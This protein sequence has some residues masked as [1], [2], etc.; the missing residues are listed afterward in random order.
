VRYIAKAK[1]D[2]AKTLMG[3]CRI[4]FTWKDHL[5]LQEYCKTKS[6]PKDGLEWILRQGDYK[7]KHKEI[8]LCMFAFLG[9]EVDLKELVKQG[10]NH[11]PPPQGW[12][13]PAISYCLARDNDRCF[14]TLLSHSTYPIISYGMIEASK[15]KSP[16]CFV[17]GLEYLPN[18]DSLLI[19]LWALW[20]NWTRPLLPKEVQK[21]ILKRAHPVVLN[22][23]LKVEENSNKNLGSQY[24]ESQKAI[25]QEIAYRKIKEQN[26]KDS[27]EIGDQ[28][29]DFI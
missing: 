16:K 26:L 2:D 12:E 27:K 17:K 24:S 22:Q 1:Y 6:N 8:A 20:D 14:E 18:K 19:T 23:L 21:A 25:L 10:V 15:Q 13:K 28:E 9:K 5:I 11:E 7:N 29:K 4:D 3:H